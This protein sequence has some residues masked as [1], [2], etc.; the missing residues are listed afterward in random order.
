MCEE[1]RRGEGRGR[2]REREGGRERRGEKGREAGEERG[3][4]DDRTCENAAMEGH[5]DCLRYV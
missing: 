2:E 5:L 3:Q 4:W 1:G